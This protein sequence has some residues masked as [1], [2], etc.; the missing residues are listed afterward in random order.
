MQKLLTML[1]RYEYGEHK[2]WSVV[3]VPSPEE[4]DGRQLHRELRSLRKEKTR[5]T[6]R[7]RGLLATQGIR[8]ES[9]MDLSDAQLEAIR[10]WNGKALPAALKSRLKREW[11]HVL[12]VKKQIQALEGERRCAMKKREGADKQQESADLDKVRQLAMLGGHWCSWELGV[13]TRALWLE[14]V[15][16]RAASGIAVGSDTDAL[17]ERR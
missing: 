11:E 10:L 17:P 15:W 6:N 4:E 7:I 2:V 9:R 14:E 12:F 13:G 3:R 8:L 1:I 5:T 16:Q